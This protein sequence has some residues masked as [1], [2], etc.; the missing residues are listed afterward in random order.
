MV[1]CGAGQH[2]FWCIARPSQMPKLASM[3]SP[4]LSSSVEHFCRRDWGVYYGLQW[5]FWCSADDNGQD[6]RPSDTP[7]D[8]LPGL[9]KR[10]RLLEY[11]LLHCFSLLS[12]CVEGN[13]GCTTVC[14]GAINVL[15]MAMGRMPG[16][17]M[18]QGCISQPRQTPTLA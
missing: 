2:V 11:L 17:T 12:I 16:Q 1:G 6:A 13:G 3:S 14:N 8:G 10:Q 15:K 4:L 5:G 7:K 9:G 18:C